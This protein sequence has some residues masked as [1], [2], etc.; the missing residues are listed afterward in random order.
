MAFSNKNKNIF[1]NFNS[2]LGNT[3]LAIVKLAD[4]Y[5]ITNP[6]ATIPVTRDRSLVKTI[7]LFYFLFRIT[8][9]STYIIHRLQ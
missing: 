5:D 2:L 4:I 6:L 3:P 9:N 8:E 1:Y 7:G